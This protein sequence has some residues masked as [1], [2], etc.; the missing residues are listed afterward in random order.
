M[1][2]ATIVAMFLVVTLVLN[3]FDAADRPSSDARVAR[4]SSIGEQPAIS[5][6]SQNSTPFSPTPSARPPR[7]VEQRAEPRA[8]ATEADVGDQDPKM[9]ASTAPI[10]D[11]AS[12]GSE[13]YEAIYSN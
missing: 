11:P 5:V 2:G 13:A 7:S 8:D 4:T 10:A 9:A 12:F 3:R 6:P 1:L